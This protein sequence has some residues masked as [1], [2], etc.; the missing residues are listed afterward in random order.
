MSKLR[1][2]QLRF[3]LWEGI[4]PSRPFGQLLLRQP[5]IPIPPPKQSKSRHGDSGDCSRRLGG[6]AKTGA[7]TRRFRRLLK[8]PVRE[9]A[10]HVGLEPTSTVLETVMLPVAPMPYVDGH[11]HEA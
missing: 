3:V 1:K 4:E 8:Q 2:N 6:S 5:R 11:T 9:A 10:R 7:A